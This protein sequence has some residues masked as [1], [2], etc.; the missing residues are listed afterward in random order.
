MQVAD[1]S[2]MFD[3]KLSDRKRVAEMDI[4]TFLSDGYAVH[5]SSE[6][7]KTLRR[8]PEAGAGEQPQLARLPGFSM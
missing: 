1:A 7:D 5:L 3:R 6:L 8:A 4:S 2:G